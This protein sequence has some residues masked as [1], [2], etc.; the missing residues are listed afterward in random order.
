MRKTFFSSLMIAALV[1]SSMWAFSSAAEEKPK[2]AGSPAKAPSP[3]DARLE[4]AKKYYIEN[5]VIGFKVAMKLGGMPLPDEKL[6]LMKQAVADWLE[7]DC[8]P[9]LIQKG[10]LDEWVNNLFDAEVRKF[11]ERSKNATSIG[12][13]MAITKEAEAYTKANYPRSYA[14]LTSPDF[15]LIATKLQNALLRVILE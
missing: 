14:A 8:M 9:F 15:K 1:A 6:P 2:T 11:N 12:D 4:E 5:A 13:F 7:K 10:L 3:A